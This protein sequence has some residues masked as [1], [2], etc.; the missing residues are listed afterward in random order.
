MTA[1]S[2]GNAT[3]VPMDDLVELGVFAPVGFPGT[4][5]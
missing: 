2:V 5:Q 4:A 3:E 1:D